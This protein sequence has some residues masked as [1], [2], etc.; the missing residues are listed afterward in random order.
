MTDDTW[1][2][3]HLRYLASTAKAGEAIDYRKESASI[4]LRLMLEVLPK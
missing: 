4:R 1:L 3:R 2:E